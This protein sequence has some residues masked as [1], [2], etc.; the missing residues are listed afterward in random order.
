MDKDLSELTQ[1]LSERFD[2]IEHVLDLKADK[3]DVRILSEAVDAYAK[4][5]EY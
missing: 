2:K 4:K 3:E 5:L 1:Y